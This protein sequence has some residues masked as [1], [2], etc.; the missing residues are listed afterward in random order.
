[1]RRLRVLP[2]PEDHH[3][4][5]LLETLESCLESLRQDERELILEYYR[6]EHAH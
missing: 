3:E 6:G 4:D 2:P 1:M 5:G